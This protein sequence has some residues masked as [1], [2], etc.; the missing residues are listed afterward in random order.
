MFLP[1]VWTT[2]GN[3]LAGIFTGSNQSIFQHSQQTNPVD[4]LFDIFKKILEFFINMIKTLL[5]LLGVKT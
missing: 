4:S 5:G 1:D 2:T 3:F